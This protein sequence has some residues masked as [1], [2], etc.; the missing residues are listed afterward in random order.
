MAYQ[1][2][3]NGKPAD[4]SA[5]GAGCNMKKNNGWDNSRFDKMMD[6]YEYAYNWL[7]K[8]YQPSMDVN[9]ACCHQIFQ[10]PYTYSGAGDTIQVKE[11]K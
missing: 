2:F 5:N 6:A 1:V 3:D 9:A 11:V 7:G 4:T 10:A 8:Q